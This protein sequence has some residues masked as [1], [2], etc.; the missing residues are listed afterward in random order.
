MERPQ[1]R[2]KLHEVGNRKVCAARETMG[3]V[4]RDLFRG[5]FR[6]SRL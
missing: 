5:D 1:G 3:E 6:A 4:G 2:N